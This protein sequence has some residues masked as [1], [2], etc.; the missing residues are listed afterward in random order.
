MHVCI[1]APS[2]APAKL[3]AMRIM[4]NGT[5]IGDDDNALN[6]LPGQQQWSYDSI[7]KILSFNLPGE[8]IYDVKGVFG[9]R[10]DG[11]T[12]DTAAIQ[13]AFDLASAKG[14]IVY[15]P[16]VG[17][18]AYAVSST[19]N[20][21][22]TSGDSGGIAVG[23]VADS[24][25]SMCRI[26][27]LGD[28]AGPVFNCN[29]TSASQAHSWYVSGLYVDMTN[30]PSA[31]GL[32]VN[33]L[34]RLN[35]DRCQFREG[36]IGLDV[37]A[38]SAGSFTRT[39]AYNSST[40]GFRYASGT[41]TNSQ[42]HNW[43]GCNFFMSSGVS[44]DC[45][46]G[47]LD[48][49]GHQDQNYFGCQVIRSPGIT[50]KLPWGFKFD[51]SAAPAAGQTF[52]SMCVADAITDGNNPGTGS[53][54]AAYAFLKV[55]NAR[56]N[57]CWASALDTARGWRTPCLYIDQC[58]RLDVE[59][60]YMSG[61]GVAFGNTAASDMCHFRGNHFPNPNVADACFQ[62][63]AATPTNLVF[64]GNTREKQAA[65]WFDNYATAQAGMAAPGLV[66]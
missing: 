65:P 43:F 29:P 30:A 47:W 28:I 3:Q 49:S 20:C 15:F 57:Q 31:T 42:G 13:A 40:A 23:I 54:G 48:L 4:V 21:Q 45:N 26:K 62:F 53:T 1:I 18:G 41:T 7:N 34:Q 8:Q 5:P 60:V 50:F 36:T 22:G 9:A 27:C 66:G 64:L 56:M 24:T 61:T 12:D 11:V 39:D 63:G 6:L 10:G 19:I 33:N 16:P 55:T 37:G 25:Q 52:M 38:V 17:A 51:G 35:V 2:A 14:G 44:H 32:Y 58:T 59:N 46:A